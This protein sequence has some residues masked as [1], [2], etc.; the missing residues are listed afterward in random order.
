MKNIFRTTVFIAVLAFA[1]TSC[2]APKGTVSASSVAS[3]GKFTGKWVLGSIK[4]DG[5]IERAVNNVFDQAPPAAFR[6]STWEF[7]N[8]GNGI[9][10]LNTGVSQTIFWSI[11]NTDPNGQILQ[12]KKI[13]QGDKP[14]NVA[15]G[16]QL[17]V[18]SIDAETMTLKSPI[19][20]GDKTAYIIYAF[21][22][23]S[24]L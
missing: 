3:R 10:T 17:Y 11:N 1:F 15:E 9:Y 22:R 8:S 5:L 6:G 19:A 20:L 7:T 4:Y 2:N 23:K 12:F 16:Y 18:A 13:Y 21:T 14:K 24:P